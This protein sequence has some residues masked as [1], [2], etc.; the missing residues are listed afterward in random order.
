[1]VKGF[2]L[3]LPITMIAMIM[4]SNFMGTMT[5][6]VYAKDS[7]SRPWNRIDPIIRSHLLRDTQQI[8]KMNTTRVPNAGPSSSDDAP[9]LVKRLESDGKTDVHSVSPVSSTTFSVLEK[10]DENQQTDMQDVA[11]LGETNH[12][13]TDAGSAWNL[14]GKKVANL[15]RTTSNNVLSEKGN[16]SEPLSEVKGITGYV[17]ENGEK[18]PVNI[19]DYVKYP[20]LTEADY[21]SNVSATAVIVGGSCAKRIGNF[22]FQ[23]AAMYGIARANGFT[24]YLTMSHKMRSCFDNITWKVKRLPMELRP[25]GRVKVT[26]REAGRK[27]RTFD[28]T[29]FFLYKSHPETQLHAIGGYRQSW[30]YFSHVW[31]GDLEHQLKCSSEHQGIID[32]YLGDVLRDQPEGTVIVGMHVRRGDFEEKVGKGYTLSNITYMNNAIKYYEEKHRHCL[33]V[34]ASNGIQ[35]CKENINSS[36][37]T[38][39]F[40]PFKAA[41]EDLCLMA[42]CNDSIITGGSYGWWGAYMAGGFVV[43]DR[44]FPRLDSM[45]GR[46]YTKEDYYPSHW[47]AL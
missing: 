38:V 21:K 42:S 44:E 26:F 46:R 11:I 5:T 15:N 16:K 24:P 25:N 20:V 3:A 41:I 1:M 2:L 43:Y 39:V 12:K 10:G 28:N 17:T 45:I 14:G 34:V 36:R 8:E 37:S 35:W 7:T 9:A 18:I 13:Q 32:R 22:L 4:Y 47:V 23:F 33:F 30:K 40:S 31:E 6:P 27:G 29:A 19:R